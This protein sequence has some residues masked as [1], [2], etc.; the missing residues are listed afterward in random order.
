MDVREDLY[1][2]ISE[3]LEDIEEVRH[4][5]LWNRN[6]EFIEEEE[7]WD[8]PAVFIEILPIRWDRLESRVEYR[9]EPR[10]HLHIVTDWTEGS[11]GHPGIGRLLSLPEKIHQKLAG[12]NGETF[13]QLDLVESITN[14]NHGEIVEM[15]EAYEAFGSRIFEEKE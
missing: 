14:H 13:Y 12:L 1:M 11:E 5:D 15:I 4:I 6:V 7:A 10:V 3:A 2:R 9:C 8:R